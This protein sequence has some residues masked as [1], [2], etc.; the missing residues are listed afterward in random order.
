MPQPEQKVR[1]RVIRNNLEFIKLIASIAGEKSTDEKVD[2]WAEKLRTPEAIFEFVQNKVKYTRDPITM[3]TIRHPQVLLERVEKQGYAYGDCDCKTCL[4]ASLLL[5]RGYP[6]RFLAAHIIKPNETK[7]DYNNINHTYLE[8][9]DVYSKTPDKWLPLE[10]SSKQKVAVGFK[11]P[12]V[13]D[14]YRVYV[15]VGGQKIE[16]E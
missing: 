7:K 6:V 1:Y 9:R 3:D 14:V 8:F 13:V 15:S 2:Q 12:N 4:L 5:N 11:A 10:P 16:E